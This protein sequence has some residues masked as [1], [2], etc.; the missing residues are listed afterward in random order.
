MKKLK[1]YFSIYFK[2][3]GQDIKS[4][5]SYRA[6]FFISTIGMILTDAVEI[7]AF[8]ITFLNFPS[9][10]GWNFYE[11]LFM[12]G[13]SLIA[14]TPLQCLFDNNWSLRKYVYDGDF[15]KYCF[16]PINLFFYFISEV[17]DLKGLGQ[18]AVGIAALVFAWVNLSLPV[19]FVIILAL[20]A[21]IITASLFMVGIMNF[22]AA[23]CFY[24]INSGYIM[25]TMNKFRDY[26]KYPVT[27]FSSVFKV[28]FTFVIPI[29]FIAFYPSQIF[30][31]PDDI[32]I[33]TW[34]APFYGILF[35]YLS[36]RFWMRGAKK[37]SGTGS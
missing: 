9:V 29:A 1:F 15:I 5:M 17:F 18:L 14:M 16:R 30:L 23:T 34:V 21:A 2:I 24:V 10:C 19:S 26:A 28:I 33:L 4:K 32:P 27:I 37:Y 20:I 31:R 6:D 13:F 36:Y 7:L 12:Y 8:Y 35:F 11:M 3:I 22:A 25:I